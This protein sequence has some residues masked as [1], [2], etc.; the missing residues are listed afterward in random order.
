MAG[1]M[2]AAMSM[3]WTVARAVATGLVTEH[4]PFV[5]TAKGGSARK[6]LA[7]PAFYEAV[8]GGLLILGAAI[9]FATNHEAVREIYLFGDVLIVQ[10]LP[11]LAAA[12]L[13]FLEETRF[14]S[15]AFWADARLRVRARARLLAQTRLVAPLADL[16]R[17]RAVVT[18]PPPAAPAENRA[19]SA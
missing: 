5:R 15:F 1:A 18:I 2:I 4:L 13:A 16:L 19:E 8:M 6:R 14:N 7:F 12:T 3:Q 10:S 9:V 17:R 11:F